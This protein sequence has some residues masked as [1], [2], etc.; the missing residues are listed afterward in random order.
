MSTVQADFDRIALLAADGWDHNSYYHGYLLK[1]LPAA[2]DAALDIG[3]GT[4]TFARLLAGRARR[5]VALDLSPQMIAVARQRSQQFPNIR[6]EVADALAWEWDGE[7][8]DCA[9]SIAMLHH[10][11]AEEMLATMAGLLHPGG[12]LAALD[13]YQA[14][15]LRDLLRALAARP[16]SLGLTL[17]KTGR[18]RQPPQVR[19]AWEEHGRHE[20]YPTV[21]QVRRLCARVLPGARVRQHLFWRY[22]ILWR[23]PA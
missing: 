14:E 20:T 19:A 11:P 16:L 13:L 4:G 7:P 21:A 10:V 3:C 18:L 1:H 23:K 17:L 9:V 15:G 6:Y 22:S 2:C 12:T 5:V 8:F